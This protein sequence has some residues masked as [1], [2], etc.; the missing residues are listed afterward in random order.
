MTFE[1]SK[2]GLGRGFYIAL[3][4]ALSFLALGLFLTWRAS[5]FSPAEVHSA[6]HLQDEGNAWRRL[7]K[8]MQSP[9]SNQEE[10]DALQD[11]LRQF[12]PAFP[13]TRR[14]AQ[15]LTALKALGAKP[16]PR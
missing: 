3:G 8:R 15:A 6:E 9:H 1:Q 13:P 11:Y 16:P 2:S 14:E 5:T 4:I 10:I 7:E 12:P